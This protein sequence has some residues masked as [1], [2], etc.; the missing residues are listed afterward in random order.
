MVSNGQ[1]VVTLAARSG[2]VLFAAE[3]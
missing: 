1:I 2:V 3:D